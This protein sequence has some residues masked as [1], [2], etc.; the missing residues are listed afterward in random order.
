MQARVA[1]VLAPPRALARP[2]RLA[3]GDCAPGPKMIGS[4][5]PDVEV[6]AGASM[7]VTV[8]ARSHLWTVP[9]PNRG[10]PPRTPCR[11]A[12]GPETA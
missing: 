2:G 1:Q 7:C 5:V 6:D 8:S 12:G 11:G 9:S 10:E 3:P 4:D